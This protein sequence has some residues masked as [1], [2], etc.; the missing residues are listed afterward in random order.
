MVRALLA[1]TRGTGPDSLV[2]QQHDVGVRSGGK[3]AAEQAAITAATDARR[4][5]EEARLERIRKEAKER[6]VVMQAAARKAQQ[7]LLPPPSLPRFH[8]P[9]RTTPCLA[10]TRGG[11]YL[12]AGFAKARPFART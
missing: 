9:R 8:S 3:Q 6:E 12:L 2:G 1:L 10:V 7:V 4:V 11:G 5:S